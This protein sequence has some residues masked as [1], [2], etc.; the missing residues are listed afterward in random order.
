VRFIFFRHPSESP[1]NACFSLLVVKGVTKAI[2]DKLCIRNIYS[3]TTWNWIQQGSPALTR[4]CW[5]T[6]IKNL[7]LNLCYI[8]NMLGCLLLL[9]L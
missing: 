8:Q 6:N 3:E 9:E 4:K 7:I 5:V 2:T 1:T